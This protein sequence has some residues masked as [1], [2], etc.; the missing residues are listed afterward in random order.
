MTKGTGYLPSVSSATVYCLKDR[1]NHE[2][3]AFNDS[4]FTQSSGKATFC[5]IYLP[6]PRGVLQEMTYYYGSLWACL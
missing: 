4:N 3:D 1:I 6:C 5:S 2:H